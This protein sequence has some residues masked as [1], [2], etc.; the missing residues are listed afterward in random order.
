[1]RALKSILLA[2]AIICILL[3]YTQ[4][5]IFVIQPIGAIPEGHTLVI[6]R[7]NKMEFIDSADALCLREIE[8]VN[9]LCRGAA[10]AAVSEN[11]YILARMAY[12]KILY[13]ISTGG[14]SFER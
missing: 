12:S 11:S 14:R 6:L 1:M 7:G 10:L 13:D 3:M 4:L 8:S 2:L 5:T 9:L